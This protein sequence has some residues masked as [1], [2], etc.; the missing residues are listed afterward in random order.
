VDSKSASMGAVSRLLV[1]PRL[2]T[3]GGALCLLAM[4]ACQPDEDNLDESYHCPLAG[5]EGTWRWLPPTP[6]SVSEVNPAEM[7]GGVLVSWG[8]GRHYDSTLPSCAPG[9]DCYGHGGFFFDLSRDEW[10]PMSEIGAPMPRADMG[11]A[12]D[13]SRIAFW[14]GISTNAPSVELEDGGVYDPSTDS[15]EPIVDAAT[16][17]VRRSPV[18]VWTGSKLLV[19]GGYDFENTVIDESGVEWATIRKDGLVYDAETT[20]WTRMSD[21]GAPDTQPRTT[22]WTG[23]E[24]LLF[25]L[26]TAEAGS[27]RG[28]GYD[29]D[30]DAWR[31]ISTVGAP[32]QSDVSSA[33]WTGT[34]YVTFGG[35]ETGSHRYRG[36]GA[37]YNP[38]TDSWRP[39][40][41]EGAPHWPLGGAVWTGRHALVMGRA[42]C[43]VAAK[44][45]PVLD[46]WSGHSTPGGG[47]EWVMNT[48][49]AGN[50]LLLFG[51][52]REYDIVMTGQLLETEP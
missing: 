11:V 26:G 1:D 6:E 52:R 42:E 9:G 36:G 39:L 44:Y 43:P 30:D 2:W 32:S 7:A 46:Q 50:G 51:D 20:R 28:Y 15:W 12:T 31:T 25:A 5:G 4:V 3:A 14:G 23:S 13:G 18:V 29:P 48:F 19:W 35:T 47:Y 8:S 45:D 40:N 38:T 22:V 21:V 41:P 10:A 17:D 34:E 24:L 49:W 27:V 37:A 33:T 16:G